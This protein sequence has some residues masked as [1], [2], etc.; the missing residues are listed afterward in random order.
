MAT[1]SR[2][3]RIIGLDIC[4]SA[5]ILTVMFSHSITEASLYNHYDPDEGF[6][7]ALRFLI[8][9]APP[10]FIILF[11][12]MLEIVYRPR[13]EAGEGR[14]VTARLLTRALQCYLLYLLSLVAAW[15]GGINS[16]G[17]TLRC[18]LMM[19]VTPYTDILKFYAVALA[20]AP[21]LIYLRLKIGI[22][23]L[24]LLAI[25]VHLAFP[26]ISEAVIEGNSFF[27][28]YS[29]P[30]IGFLIGGHQHYIGGPSVLHAMTF[31]IGGMLFG[32]VITLLTR[33]TSSRS[34]ILNAIGALLAMYLIAAATL[35][36]Y[37]TLFGDPMQTIRDIASMLLRNENHPIYFAFGMASAMTV[38]ITALVLYD[39]N[40]VKFGRPVVFAGQS[41]L[42]TF[43][44][45]NSLLYIAP[46]LALSTAGAWAYGLALFAVICA[47]SYAFHQLQN[48]S[49][50]LAN[51][52]V[53]HL[54][55]AL[56]RITSAV[57]RLP[58]RIA[59]RYAGLLGW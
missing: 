10:I 15:I 11:G 41:S 37:F 4:R 38:V 19:G 46:K 51:P 53:A 3:S 35:T 28:K 50:A 36:W 31:V 5:A 1:A 8:Q 40:G 9:I 43:S 45:G 52:H 42:F 7:L 18:A 48:T 32:R 20:L 33:E 21:G 16:L 57:A 34:D 17:Y 30:V 26:M 39:A 23:I 47:M 13:V 27:A 54:Q 22:R 49:P 55:Q 29:N 24:A 56:G 44:L 59:P 12:S 58:R 2:Q 25:G 14:D 6:Y